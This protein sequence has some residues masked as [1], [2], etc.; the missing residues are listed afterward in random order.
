MKDAKEYLWTIADRQ[1]G[2][3]MDQ[4][5]RLIR[6]AQLDAQVDMKQR[7]ANA[8]EKRRAECKTLSGQ[9]CHAGDID[10]ILALEER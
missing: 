4:Q 3:A 5:I 9:I 8:C 10:A 1:T 6:Q 7:A 2:F